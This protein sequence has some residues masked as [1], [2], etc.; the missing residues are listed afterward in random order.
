MLKRWLLWLLKGGI[1]LGLIWWVL[2]KVDLAHAWIQARTVDPWMLAVAILLSLFQVVVGAAR[3]GV[4][5]RALAARVATGRIFALYYLGVFFASVLPGA[6]GGDAMRMWFCHRSGMPL[7]A[8]VN[9]VMLERLVT[10][11]AL[12]LL[13]AFTQ[14]ILLARVPGLPGSWVFPLLSLGGV[15]G[16][17]VL[18]Q[19]DRLPTGLGRWRVV[20]GLMTLAGDCRRL[21]FRPRYGAP[22][23][24]LAM[25]GHVNLSL[26]VYALALGLRLH[27][28]AL[29]CIVLV[30]P[31]ILIMTLPISIAGWGVRETAMVTAFGFIGVPSG[32]AL[33]L[34]ILF[35]LV[36]TATALPGGGFWLGSGWRRPAAQSA[37]DGVQA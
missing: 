29:D 7:S 23:L 22:A 14:P 24:G 32:S 13:V 30:P 2:S 28:D 31:I 3:W 16:L 34:S 33:V 20:R 10:V 19:L 6:V 21:C 1:S 35:G 18:S 27:V 26:V 36:T 15:A 25:F 12:V 5:L 37:A 4:V 9:S 8:A 17:L 11:V